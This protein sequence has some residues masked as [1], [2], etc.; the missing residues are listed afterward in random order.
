MIYLRKN[1]MFCSDVE[2]YG[3]NTNVLI[4]SKG[5]LDGILLDNKGGCY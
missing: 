4:Y 3:I 5:A 2:I 1:H